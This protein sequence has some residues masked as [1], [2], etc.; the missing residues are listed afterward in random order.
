MLSATKL[1]ERSNASAIYDSA[2]GQIVLFGGYDPSSG[3]ATDATWTFDGRRWSAV[4]GVRP[5]A[6]D[7]ASIVYDPAIR[8]VVL[9]GGEGGYARGP[10]GISLNNNGTPVNDT[11]TFDGHRWSV[12]SGVMPPARYSASMIYDPTTGRVVLFGGTGNSG[13]I[14]GTSIG[15]SQGA[16]NDTWT[17]DGHRWSSVSG[18]T[19][20]ARASASMIYDPAIRRVVLY[21][22]CCDTNGYLNDTYL[23]DGQRWSVASGAHPLAREQASIVY[24][25]NR[26]QALMF[27]GSLGDTWAY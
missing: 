3:Q 18:D 11:W 8:R 6:R 23:F 15:S 24:D 4:P 27:G 10:E 26:R 12:V 20:P 17:F 19:P 9:F 13:G 22:G 14:A 21:G 16:L 7:S 2:T 25:E 1:P 5:S